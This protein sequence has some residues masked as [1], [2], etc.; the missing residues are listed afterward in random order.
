MDMSIGLQSNR[1]C[2]LSY[3]P[4]WYKGSACSTNPLIQA[5]FQTKLN[6]CSLYIAGDFSGG[7]FYEALLQNLSRNDSALKKLGFQ[8]D[9]LVVDED[10]DTN[11]FLQAVGQIKLDSLSIM[12]VT[13]HVELGFD[14]IGRLQLQLLVDNIPRMKIRELDLEMLNDDDEDENHLKQQLLGA[15]KQNFSLRVVDLTFQNVGVQD[16]FQLNN[17]DKARIAFY[18]GRNERFGG[19]TENPSTVPTDLWPNALFLAQQASKDSLFE[20]LKALSGKGIGLARS[21]RKRTRTTFY[22]PS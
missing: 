20:S 3:D 7:I 19:W 17:A 10:F 12:F 14:R 13:P 2:L 21:K 6:L 9:N 11:G 4:S 22:K 15:V 1:H 18:S 8:F 5:L 16:D